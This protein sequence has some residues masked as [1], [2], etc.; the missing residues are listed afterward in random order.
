MLDAKM[1]EDYF[2]ENPHPFQ[3]PFDQL[4]QP[5]QQISHE[6]AIYE[7]G[8]L[9]QKL[10]DLALDVEAYFSSQFVLRQV[11]QF[12]GYTVKEKTRTSSMVV[13]D[14]STT[15]NKVE[16]Q[17]WTSPV[18]NENAWEDADDGYGTSFE[19]GF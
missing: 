12:T 11:S 6:F 7:D 16:D 8:D 2:K 13:F 17:S 1:V 4:S 18:S 15:A 10:G 9:Y 14:I 5:H 19:V 3:V